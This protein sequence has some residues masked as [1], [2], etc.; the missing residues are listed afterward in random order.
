MAQG[1]RTKIISMIKCIRTSKLSIKN[2]LSGVGGGRE[3]TW[4]LSRANVDLSPLWYKFVNF[5]CENDQIVR[6]VNLGWQV[7]GRGPGPGVAPPPAAPLRPGLR[8]SK[9]NLLCIV[10]LRTKFGHVTP[11]FVGER[12]PRSP[13]C[14]ESTWGGSLGK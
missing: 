12:S 7:V 6:F 1:R 4:S 9:V 10:D 2:C 3:G 5:W 11:R 13:P 14:G 8:S